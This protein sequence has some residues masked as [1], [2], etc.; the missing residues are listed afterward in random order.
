MKNGKV[1]LLSPNRRTPHTPIKVLGF[2]WTL[3]G[4][5]ALVAFATSA[6]WRVSG[7]TMPQWCVLCLIIC[8]SVSAWFS[9][10]G[11]KLAARMQIILMV[12]LFF[13][14]LT[15]SLFGAWRGKY[16]ALFYVSGGVT[17]M[18]VTTLATHLVFRLRK[19]SSSP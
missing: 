5:A 17:L 7:I 18:A 6:Q 3:F 19:G 16:D 13:P 10:R 1:I 12:V 2:F 11:N 4:L 15:L 9:T 8:L 14:M